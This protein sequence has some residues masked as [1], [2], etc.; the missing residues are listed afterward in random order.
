M[1]WQLDK[2]KPR[3]KCAKCG[4]SIMGTPRYV[5]GLGFKRS[6]VD[7]G[8]LL[9]MIREGVVY[10]DRRTIVYRDDEK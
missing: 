9:K 5:R 6:Y 4:D 2:T 7:A 1:N 3:K 10:K 8:C